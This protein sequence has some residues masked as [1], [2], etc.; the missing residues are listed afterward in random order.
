MATGGVE[1]EIKLGVSDDFRFPVISLAGAEVS[2]P[3]TSV[4]DAVYWDTRDLALQRQGFGLRHRRRDGNAGTWTVKG[5]SRSTGEAVERP[6]TEVDAGRDTLPETMLAVLPDGVDAAALVPVAWL[7]TTRTAR[8]IG[9]GGGPRALEV[10]D[11]SVEILDEDGHVIERFREVEV[12]I[13]EPHGGA[14]ADTVV[15][16][17]RAA[18]A[19]APAMTSKL[20][21]ALRARGLIA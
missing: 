17:L 13:V 21:R 8:D 20:A 15:A 7:H 9:P 14:L 5:P 12:E 6:E 2:E 1:R 10:V 3:V 11:D 4:L 16:A 19:S 18:G